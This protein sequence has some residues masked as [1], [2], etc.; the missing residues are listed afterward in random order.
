MCVNSVIDGL[1]RVDVIHLIRLRK[2]TFYSRIFNYLENSV[3]CRL[4][5]V[6]LNGSNF[7]DVCMLA[8]LHEKAVKD[9]LIHLVLLCTNC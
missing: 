9:I 8:V 2:I 4:L 6:F 3:L 1:G 7:Y 5:C